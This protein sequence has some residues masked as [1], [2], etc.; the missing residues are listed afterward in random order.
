[1]QTGVTGPRMTTP[2]S[3]L[4]PAA[5]APLAEVSAITAE[6]HARRH[7]YTW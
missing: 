6:M 3:P 7:M 5:V 4:L 1:M 2:R